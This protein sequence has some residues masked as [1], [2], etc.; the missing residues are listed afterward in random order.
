MAAALVAARYGPVGVTTTA[1]LVDNF[2]DFFWDAK[3]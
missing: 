3:P 1:T 2:D